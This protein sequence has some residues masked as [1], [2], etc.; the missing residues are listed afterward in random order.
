MLV[1]DRRLTR[2]GHVL[3]YFTR[4]FH[5]LLDRLHVSHLG[6]FGAFVHQAVGRHSTSGC[7]TD[8]TQHRTHQH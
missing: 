2:H 1:L 4:G 3:A 6:D 5:L 8:S 7:Y